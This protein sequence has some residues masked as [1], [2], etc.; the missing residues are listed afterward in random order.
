VHVSIHGTHLAAAVR[1][2][3][4]VLERDSGKVLAEHD[5]GPGPTP[6]AKMIQSS[7]S[8][9]RFTPDGE[10]V[11]IGQLPSVRVLDWKTGKERAVI[12]DCSAVCD[13][14]PSPDGSLI[15]LPG[16]VLQLCDARTFAVT[17]RIELEG[18]VSAAAFAPDGKTFAVAGDGVVTFLDVA[19]GKKGA[20]LAN[21]SSVR[22]IAVHDIAW[23]PDGKFIATTCEDGYVRIWDAD[24]REV[25]RELA[26]HDTTI[27]GTGARNLHGVVFAPDGGVLYVGGAPVGT[28]AVTEYAIAPR[29]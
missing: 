15:A 14:F 5:L 1:D 2:K 26:G 27:P 23:S 25:V 8:F 3:L 21:A 7:S 16:Y 11:L 6:F 4:F 24:N 17:R 9:A 22:T 10:S 12:E 19:T 20:S 13:A 29:C 28:R 18:Y